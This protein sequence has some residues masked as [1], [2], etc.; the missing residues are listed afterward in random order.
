MKKQIEVN[1]KNQAYIDNFFKEAEREE[2]KKERALARKL[3]RE[4]V[5]REAGKAKNNI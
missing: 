2:K 4:E 5:K 3:K 1:P